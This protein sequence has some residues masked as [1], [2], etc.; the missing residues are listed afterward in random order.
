MMNFGL[1]G[2][3]KRFLGPVMWAYLAIRVTRD[4]A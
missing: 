4:A 2:Y 3:R 1:P